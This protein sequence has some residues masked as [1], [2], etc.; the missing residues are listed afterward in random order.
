[1]SLRVESQFGLPSLPGWM[2]TLTCLL[3]SPPLAIET[4][5]LV[6][7]THFWPSNFVASLTPHLQWG[8][9]VSKKIL[10]YL[11]WEVYIPK[12]YRTVDCACFSSIKTSSSDQW[13]KPFL[14]PNPDPSPN[15]R[16]PKTFPVSCW[17]RIYMVFWVDVL[18]LSHENVTKNQ[19]FLYIQS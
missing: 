2:S 11:F 16:G 7:T 5:C 1:M 3:L 8:G 15:E 10:L 12:C 19:L 14:H 9:E 17:F 13:A 18:Q 4:L 6:L